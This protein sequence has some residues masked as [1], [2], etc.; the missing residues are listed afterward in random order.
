MSLRAILIG[1]LFALVVALGGHFNDVYMGQTYMVGNFL[2]ISVVGFLV[3]IVLVFGPILHRIKPG[4]NFSAS[5]LAVI[6]ALPLAVCVVPGSGFLRT[7]TPVMVM[8]KHYEKNMPS[9]QKSD[10]FSYVPEKLLVVAS[11]ENEE[12]VLGKFL[13]GG[14]T[15]EEH[16]NLGDIP[17]KSWM[18][19]LRAWIPF[20]SILM[21]GL[22][23]LSLV[24]HRQWTTHEHLV[25]PVAEF[26][27]LITAQS[28]GRAYP[29]IVRD[30]MFWY[31]FVPV[32]IIH[33]VN[34]L[35]AWRPSF[36]EIPHAI[37]I[38]PLLELFPKLASAS[39]A[40]GVFGGMIF[41]T[42]VAFS[43]FLPSD[44]TLSLGLTN[45]ITAIFSATMITYGV[46]ASYVW[47]GDGE[48]QGFLFGAYAGVLVLIMYNGRSYYRRVLLAALGKKCK[49]TELEPSAVWGCRVFLVTS[50]VCTVIMTKMGISWPFAIIV[51]ALLTMLFV[52]MSR[53][54]AETGLF[55]MQPS[56]QAAAILV[57]LFGASAIGL[58]VLAVAILVC[59]VITIDPREAM[60]PFIINALRI[61]EN[62]GV[63]RG[64][65]SAMMGV[66]LLV[67]LLGGL[68]MVLWLQYDRGVGL[69]D[70]F[71]TDAVPKMG[72]H[73]LDNQIQK[74]K[75]DGVLEQSNK[76]TWIER[77][78]LIQPKKSFVAFMVAGFGLFSLFAF[79]RFRFAK[80]PLHPILFLVWFTYP[81]CCLAWSFL[82]G[83]AIKALVVKFGG[84]ASYQRAKP[85]MVGLIAAD[86][87]GGLIFMVAGAIYYKV[88][89]FAPAR[90]SIFPG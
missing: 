16:I 44:I 87:L 13:Q 74:M 71:A 36:I 35:R 89:G 51:M 31:G 17:W 60:M 26:V 70:V 43:F 65:L 85:L 45:L 80:W 83:W 64:R 39:S 27:Q 56:W 49:D 21:I 9:W 53:I 48:I 61:A 88:T 2:P 3:V 4:W 18:P 14:G 90:Y 63:K 38:W 24:L 29:A 34:G 59:L 22:I 40:W 69:N 33:I 8:P 32:L 77:L 11:P 86:L 10:V 66:T 46:S 50:V 41:F 7:F 25:Y 57:G 58:E 23:G 62:A 6:V 20:F 42:V 12:E 75:A 54:C 52:A 82:I 73:F 84:G 5:E 72:F 55:F 68:V 79:L 19:A 15:E 1:F 30:R 76:A 47:M 37:N 81:L 78:S 67:C 28:E